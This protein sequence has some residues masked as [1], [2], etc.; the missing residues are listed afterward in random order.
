MRNISSYEKK[1]AVVA[2][3]YCFSGP[4]AS[5]MRLPGDFHFWKKV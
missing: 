1:A 4:R 2:S 5:V 3:S